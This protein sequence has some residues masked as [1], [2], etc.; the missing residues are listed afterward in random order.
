MTL[1]IVIVILVA[2]IFLVRQAIRMSINERKSVD[3]YHHALEALKYP[4]GN[5]SHAGN[6]RGSSGREYADRGDTITSSASSHTAERIPPATPVI[7]DPPSTIRIIGRA[8]ADTRSADAMVEMEKRAELARQRLIDRTGNAHRGSRSDQESSRIEQPAGT[9]VHNTTQY[10]NKAIKGVHYAGNQHFTGEQDRESD[11]TVRTEYTRQPD[12]VFV[13]DTL[14]VGSSRHDGTDTRMNQAQ[15]E[16][17]GSASAMSETRHS[18]GKPASPLLVRMGWLHL[19]PSWK[20]MAAALALIMVAL[21]LTLTSLSIGGTPISRTRGSA[22][23]RPA[24]AGQTQPVASGSSRKGTAS[25]ASANK[26]PKTSNRK[27]KN[28]KGGTSSTVNPYDS[29]SGSGLIQPV[30]YTTF[31]GSYPAPPGNYAVTLSPGERCWVMAKSQS[32]GSVLWTG[33]TYP[34][35]S[36]VIS[37]SGTVTI[38]LGAA[39]KM[40]V[41]IAGKLLAFPSG[42]S[43]P[44]TMTLTPVP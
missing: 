39:Y 44:F 16:L 42:Y 5:T 19:R 38:E 23:G 6:A 12:M 13:D 24:S 30:S 34:G 11:G 3:R 21:I 41:T 4:P 1:A 10:D 14:P 2:G 15:A 32:T 35:Q 40:S 26:H 9:T 7:P 25:T 22:L 8:P 20:R 36:Q 31:T 28:H 17:Y 33:M 43:S 29:N 27:T 18:A 37:A